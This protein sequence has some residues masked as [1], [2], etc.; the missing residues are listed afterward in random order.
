MDMAI[1]LMPRTG[2]IGRTPRLCRV[3]VDPACDDDLFATAPIAAVA[4]WQTTFDDLAFEAQA[5]TRM[6]GPKHAAELAALDPETSNALIV[7]GDVR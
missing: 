3:D 6:S 2:Q 7:W 4:S 1:Q 5:E